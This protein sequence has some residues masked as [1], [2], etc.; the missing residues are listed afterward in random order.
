MTTS[1]LLL[2]ALALRA[3]APE[4]PDEI[5]KEVLAMFKGTWQVQL[6]R[7]GGDDDS[8]EDVANTTVTFG[9]EGYEIKRGA[10]S[11][12][13][14]FKLDAV[15]KPGNI[16]MTPDDPTYPKGYVV[17]GIF[18]FEGD[19]LTMAYGMGSPA[20]P[21]ELASKPQSRTILLVLKRAKEAAPADKADDAN[22][23]DTDKLQGAWKVDS[24]EFQ[25]KPFPVQQLAMEG[26][27]FDVDKFTDTEGGKPGHNGKFK[28]D[29]STKPATIDLMDKDG[30]VFKKGIYQFD[31]DALK[32]AFVSGDEGRPTELASKAGSSVVVI[33]LKRDKK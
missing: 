13:G 11:D 1:V 24:A 31:G 5:N 16:D 12:T 30:K 26:T 18:R 23:K 17:R 14:V 29:A 9:D 20:R 28:V 10:R 25:G 27:T 32:M 8:A 6:M 33:T 21:T 2:A 7:R 15:K 19:T 4:S 22:K 3:P